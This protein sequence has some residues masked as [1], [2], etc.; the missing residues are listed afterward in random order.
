MERTRRLDG[1]ILDGRSRY[2]LDPPGHAF[3]PHRVMTRC[4]PRH[5]HQWVKRELKRLPCHDHH[6]LELSL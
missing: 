4:L 1:K 6:T 5:S 2:L 3:K